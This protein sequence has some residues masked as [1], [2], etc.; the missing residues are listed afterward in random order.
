MDFA[1][2]IAAVMLGNL[3]T[4]SIIWGMR[5]LFFIP[6][7]DPRPHWKPTLAVA[8]PLALLGVYLLSAG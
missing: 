8:V 5:K 1:D 7:S 4:I 3:F 6:M 2:A